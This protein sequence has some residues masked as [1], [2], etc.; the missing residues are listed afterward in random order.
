MTVYNRDYHLTPGVTATA[1]GAVYIDR[2]TTDLANTQEFPA[3]AANADQIQ[4]GVVPAGHVLVPQ[5]TLIQVPQIDTNGAATGK[6]KIGT[7]TTLDAVV[8]EQ[9]G[10]AAKTLFGKD[11]VLTGTVGS[12]TDDTPIYLNVSAAI[13]TQAATG[14]IVADF[15]FRAY[16]SSID[17]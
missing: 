16:E 1:A 7:A 2:Q 14:K 11:L 12:Q 15:A 3:A 6:Y 10:S 17:G 8:I 13:A 9:N 4:I 5:L